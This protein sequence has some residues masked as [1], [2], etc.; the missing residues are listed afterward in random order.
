MSRSVACQ[1]GACYTVLMDDAL[2]HVGYLLLIVGQT[3]ITQTIPGG[4]VIRASGE[5][6]WVAIGIRMRMSS[7]WLWG[8]AFTAVDIY[9]WLTWR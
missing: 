9:G 5:L 7:I 3:M 8:L 6:L 1:E 4:F 2:G